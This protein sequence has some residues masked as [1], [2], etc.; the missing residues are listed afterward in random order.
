MSHR[1]VEF[2]DLPL[3]KRPMLNQGL[4]QPPYRTPRGLGAFRRTRH[5]AGQRPPENAHIWSNAIPIS[6]RICAAHEIGAA[7]SRKA[8]F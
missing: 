8:L 4:D 6:F 7:P 3:I 1:S 2:G 5:G